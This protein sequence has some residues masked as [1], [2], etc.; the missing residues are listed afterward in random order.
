MKPVWKY[1]FITFFTL[2]V[3]GYIGYSLWYFSGRTQEKVCGKLEIKLDE[4]SGKQLITENEIVDILEQNGLN[5]IGKTVKHIQHN[6]FLL[7]LGQTN[8]R[9]TCM[10]KG[11]NLINYLQLDLFVILSSQIC[12]L[13]S[14]QT[15]FHPFPDYGIFLEN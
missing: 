12:T 9:L 14:F 11:Y 15:H 5:P 4:S 6:L 1:I 7:F 2:L 10:L 8:L 13:F 3:F